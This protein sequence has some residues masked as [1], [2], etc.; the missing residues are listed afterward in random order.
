METSLINK[1]DQSS[2]HSQLPDVISNDIEK[3]K[4]QINTKIRQIDNLKQSVQ[5]CAKQ[6]DLL[7][8]DRSVKALE[9]SNSVLSDKFKK[10]TESMDTL[11]NK[12]SVE[13]HEL[14]LNFDKMMDSMN[15]QSSDSGVSSTVI[16]ALEV[17]IDQLKTNY[18]ESEK[19]FQD[20][21]NQLYI[22]DYTLDN[23]NE[24]I[25]NMTTHSHSLPKE[26]DELARKIT[27]LQKELEE[28]KK[29]GIS[30]NHVNPEL[31]TTTATSTTSATDS[32]GSISESWGSWTPCSV[33][34]G[35]GIKRRYNKNRSSKNRIETIPCE[36]A[37]CVNWSNWSS[38]SK[39]CGRGERR[40]ENL[41]SMDIFDN[42]T[43]TQ[44]CNTLSCPAER[45]WSEV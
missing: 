21:K 11:I 40:R 29:E 20:F 1:I 27:N 43:Q 17:K 18:F 23:Q 30:N 5:S 7:P 31:D 35:K 33:T 39:S 41:L 34:C 19:D 3:I 14:E 38:C 28:A 2:S 8:L 32:T 9:I 25:K 24:K 16:A 15:S 37:S 44:P 6:A 22:L 42:N 12:L 26:I 13:F 4:I 45:P 36:E 10:D